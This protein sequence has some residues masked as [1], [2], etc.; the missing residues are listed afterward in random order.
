MMT[1]RVFL[2]SDNPSP[3]LSIPEIADFLSG[4]GISSRFCGSPLDLSAGGAGE[5]E[6]AARKIAG[7][8]ISDISA[9]R[10]E[11]SPADDAQ[12]A[13]E[14]ERVRGNFSY[15]GA[16]Y[17]ALW[18]Q[19]ILHSSMARRFGGGFEGGG[20]HL[21]FTGRLFGTFEGRYH[22]RVV[23][24]GVPAL[25]STSGL[26]EAPARPTQYYIAK[27]GYL[28][29]GLDI[30]DLDRAYR[31]R[32]IEY[33]D[34]RTTDALKSY[35]LQAILYGITGEAFCGDAACALYNSHW[36]E[37]VLRVQLGGNLCER[38]RELLSNR[39]NLHRES[40]TG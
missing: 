23:L 13:V 31:G 39:H 15:R 28:R 16:F 25:V 5:L 38:H 22:A 20:V 1:T 3:S 7:A 17:D 35:A 40:N 36:Q 14:I 11:L 27:S 9:P 6:S 32:F 8:A 10:D 4:L 33:D 34:A 37:E 24:G 19:R 30:A 18:L 12:I 2:Y 26:V 29:A 21:I